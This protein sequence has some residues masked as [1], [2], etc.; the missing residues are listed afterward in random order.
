MLWISCRAVV[1]WI[2][3]ELEKWRGREVNESMI[4][5]K[6]E[7]FWFFRVENQYFTTRNLN[8]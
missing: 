8:Y 7:L 6:I 2:F 3:V 1:N 4:E 5:L